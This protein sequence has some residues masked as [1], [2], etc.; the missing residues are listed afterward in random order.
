MLEHHIVRL[1]R[2]KSLF[3]RS[4]HQN[5]LI[6]LHLQ[7][8]H[9]TVLLLGLAQLLVFCSDVFRALVS[10]WFTAISVFLEIVLVCSWALVHCVSEEHVFLGRV[11]LVNVHVKRR[12]S[13][14]L[15]R[16]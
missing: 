12:I 4:L 9:P 10:D 1:Q 16:C 8:Y 7:R 2:L 13:A 14:T 15:N 6:N 11:V 5:I 3:A